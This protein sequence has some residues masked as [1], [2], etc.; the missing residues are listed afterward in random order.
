M[1]SKNKPLDPNNPEATV[2]EK[3]NYSISVSF[4]SK[5]PGMIYGK[6]LRIDLYVND[7]T[8]QRMLESIEYFENPE[9][10]KSRIHN[11]LIGN[12]SPIFNEMSEP[13]IHNDNLN[14]SQINAVKK[15]LESKDL[16]LVHGPPGTGKTTTLIEVIE[17]HIDRGHKVLATADSNVAVDN[18]VD[19]LTSKNRKVVRVGHPARVTETLRQHTLDFLVEDKEKYQKAQEL[20]TKANELNEKQKDYPCSTG[21]W[22]RGLS[23]DAIK[24][25]ARKGKGSRGI[26]PKK[27]KQIAKWIELQEQINSIIEKAKKFED[28]AVDEL[29]QETDVV[30]T[31][32]STAGSDLLENE[33]FDDVVIDEATQSTEPSCL[34]PMKHGNKV[35][36]AGDHKQLP[37]TILNQEAKKEGLEETLF[38]RMLEV[39]GTQIKQML[40]IQYR[41][42]TEIMSFPNTHFYGGELKA[43]DEVKNHKLEPS[44]LKE[45]PDE[46]IEKIC[47]FKN[48]ITFVDTNGNF[49]EN[50]PKGS[51]SK[52]NPEEAKIV[53]N[54]VD[55]ILNKG[56]NPEN[57]GIISP[58]DAQI[59]LLKN[60]ID[61]SGLEIKTVDGFQGREKD[62]IILSLVRS[63]QNGDIGFLTDLRRL[64]VSL[65]RARKKL[66]IIGDGDTLG[67]DRTYN[68]LMNYIA[69]NGNYLNISI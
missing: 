67:T 35:I 18:L 37:P 45:S 22:R 24:D 13:Q 10:D 42:N 54:I 3:T 29:I 17:Q 30:C 58:Y 48:G 31:T 63:N 1:I 7:I 57:I 5:P 34:I 20:R 69:E 11:I 55:R 47:D 51:T 33:Y 15:S 21:R 14:S 56:I 23:N 32:N 9:N 2:I 59:D 38:E 60:K 27:M 12:A 39:H 62:A 8:F 68:E 36:L 64:N 40:N 19:F 53:K 28:E 61:F 44:V 65:T 50:A 25:L 4:N 6:G 26:P 49:R 46:L 16:F 52:E 66:I 43:A 41:M